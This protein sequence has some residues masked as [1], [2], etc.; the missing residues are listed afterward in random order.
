SGA[1]TEKIK[2]WGHDQLSTYGIG[3]DL[4]RPAWTAVGRE[5]LRLGFLTLS[6]GE[7]PVLELTPSGVEVLRS[8][9][10]IQLTKP[11]AT[12]KAKRVAVPRAGEITCD[13]L[14][15]AALRNLRKRLA[16]E[17][18]V[19]AYIILGDATLRQ[20]ARQYPTTE[21]ELE[22]IFGMGEKKRAE[23]GGEFVRAVTSHLSQHG[24]QSF[25]AASA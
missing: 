23:F 6:E 14:L 8:R 20:M 10:T 4:S 2:R 1:E 19:P 18:K 12:P 3:R 5:L 11:L 21:S 9:Q 22:G 24:R 15:F 7:Y 13:E 25:A 17:R 16:D